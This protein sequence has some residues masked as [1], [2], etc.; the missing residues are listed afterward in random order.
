MKDKVIKCENCKQDFV[1]TKGEREFY[2]QKNLG[3]PKF[4]MICRG[5]HGKAAEDKFRKWEK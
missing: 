5:M 3:A 2:E 1:W 4:C